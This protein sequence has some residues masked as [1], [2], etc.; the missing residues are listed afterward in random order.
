MKKIFFIGLSLLGFVTTAQ[1]AV[2][3]PSAI[4]IKT[5]VLPAPDADK[6]GAMVYGYDSNGA[7]IVLREGTNNLI[8]LA[9]DPNKKGISVSCYAK[10]LEPFMKRGRELNAEGKSFNEKR[11][12]RGMEVAQGKLEMPKEPSMTYIYYGTEE[13]YNPNTGE[14]ADGQFRYVIY[15]PFATTASTGLPDKPHA[16]GMPWLMDPGTFRAPYHGGAF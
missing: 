9:D 7:M 8:C 3:L 12:I 10:K 14:L 1:E 15:T 4:Q 13:G 6:D 11:E 2:I 5:A 16:K